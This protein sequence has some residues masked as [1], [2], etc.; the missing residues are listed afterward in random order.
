MADAFQAFDSLG[1]WRPLFSLGVGVGGSGAS[2]LGFPEVL[3]LGAGTTDG[4]AGAD[5]GTGSSFWSLFCCEDCM[6]V[7]WK[8]RESAAIL[9]PNIRKW[10]WGSPAIPY[11]RADLRQGGHLHRAWSLCLETPADMTLLAR[12]H[13]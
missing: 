1:T 6:W 2:V 13:E 8:H 5:T 7:Q 12:S 10:K 11:A 4:F 9:E 3:G